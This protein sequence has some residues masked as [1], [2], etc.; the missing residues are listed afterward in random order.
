MKYFYEIVWAPLKISKLIY[1]DANFLIS[2]TNKPKLSM[3]YIRKFHDCLERHLCL[4]LW[5]LY[6]FQILIIDNFTS[7]EFWFS[8][9]FQ[10][11]KMLKMHKIIIWFHEKSSIFSAKTVLA[12][13]HTFPHCALIS[14]NF[15]RRNFVK[16]AFFYLLILNDF[17][18]FP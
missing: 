3:F 6:F 1:F 17:T 8:T 9:H 18:K 15:C 16:C 5:N 4:A 2:L 13:M 10:L 12:F 14:R 7:S 11:R